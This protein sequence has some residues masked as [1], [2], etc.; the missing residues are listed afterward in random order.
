M[1]AEIES[2]E[3]H[4]E[5]PQPS[6]DR[7]RSY[8]LASVILAV[9]ALESSINELYQQAIDRDKNALENLSEAQMKL[10][11]QLWTQA[12]EFSILRKYQVALV[13]CGRD[14]MQEGS[15]PFQSAAALIV[16]RNALT[17][18]KPEWDDSLIEHKKLERRLRSY[19]A[20]SALAERAKGRIVWFP[21][22]CLGA[23]CATWA[24]TTAEE[25]SNAFCALMQI[26]KRL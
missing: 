18:F 5:W 20:P 23:G 3:K 13:A 10:L 22:K 21:H 16:L 14:P 15:E 24:C 4:M 9:G 6:W 25:F 26:R 12:E 17:H 19:F 7:T 11:E 8:A 2:H 1:C